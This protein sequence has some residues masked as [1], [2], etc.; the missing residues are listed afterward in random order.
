M[1]GPFGG[2]PETDRQLCKLLGIVPRAAVRVNVNTDVTV[3][4]HHGHRLVA[5][6][7]DLS[8]SGFF[9]ITDQ[10]APVGSHAKAI[11]TFPG[12]Q[13]PF[14]AEA[15]VVRHAVGTSGEDQGMGLRFITFQ[16][17]HLGRLS[18]FL[19]SLYA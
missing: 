3:V 6:T 7:K 8:T 1:I 19:E 11:F 9:A 14:L 13:T 18:R 4:D 17:G 16:D 12:D 10:P 15:E 5:H 2:Q